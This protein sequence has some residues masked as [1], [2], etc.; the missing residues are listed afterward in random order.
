MCTGPRCSWRW[1]YYKYIS[2]NINA[3]ITWCWCNNSDY[4]LL[5]F[6]HHMYFDTITFFSFFFLIKFDLL[7]VHTYTVP[8]FRT[9]TFPYFCLTPIGFSLQVPFLHYAFAF[10][11]WFVEFTQ[12]S[13]CG[14]GL[15]L[16]TGAWWIYQKVCN[17][18]QHLCVSPIIDQH[19]TV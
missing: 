1:H 9:P 5:L 18:R 10:C 12:S 16:F 3:Y 7:T 13:L 19:L 11:V 8:W 17:W 2:H 15:L 14:S 6:L 4:L